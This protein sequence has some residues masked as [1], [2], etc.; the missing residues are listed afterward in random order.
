MDNGVP[1]APLTTH[2]LAKSTWSKKTITD[3]R[4]EL[5]TVAVQVFAI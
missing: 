5:A 1:L 4:A 2:A 3:G